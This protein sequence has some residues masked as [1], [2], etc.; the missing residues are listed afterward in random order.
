MDGQTGACNC[1]DHVIRREQCKHI[2]ACRLAVLDPEI[3]D[4]LR[5]VV[6]SEAA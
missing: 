6:T 5:D 1:P 3:L 2:L 4:G